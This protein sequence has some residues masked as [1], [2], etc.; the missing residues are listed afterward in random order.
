M[1]GGDFLSINTITTDDLQQMDGREGLILQGCGGN[2][3]EWLDGINELFTEA[4]IL[5]NGTK[6]QNIS[7]FEYDGLTCL[8]YPFEGVELE[9]GKLA[10]WRLQTHEQFGGTW[11]SDFVPNRLGGFVRETPIE[12]PD[13]ALIGQN[14]NIF[15][16]MGIAARTLRDH[17][18]AN[19]ANEM[20]ER[21]LASGSYGEALGI[22]GDYVNITD[23]E[24]EHKPSLREQLKDSKSAEPPVKP[25]P[26]KQRE[27]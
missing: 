18:L 7:A 2:L 16:L 8:F 11:L 23:K 12:K 21:V 24:R 4:G 20:Q 15:N 6:F 1:I 5:I 14:G 17:G 10:M 27:R 25:K 19:Q 3:Q 26:E 22:I 9:I 13:C